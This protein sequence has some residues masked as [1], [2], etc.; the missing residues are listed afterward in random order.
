M[1]EDKPIGQPID[2]YRNL[3]RECLSVKSRMTDSYGLVI[4]HVDQIVVNDASF[5]VHEPSRQ[6]VLEEEK[7]NVHAF[8]RGTWATE[9]EWNPTGEPS[10]LTYNPYQYDSF[11]E[12]NTER[13]IAAARQV[14][15]RPDET[16]T[17]DDKS[18]EVLAVGIDYQDV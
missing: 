3:G 16:S 13:P 6:R 14:C 5:I 10:K 2:V 4:D 12:Y 17:P 7:K 9:D 8:V 1:A 11:V 15:L 18:Y